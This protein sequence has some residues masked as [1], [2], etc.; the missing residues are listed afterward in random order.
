MASKKRVTFKHKETGAE[1]EG[2]ESQAKTLAKSGWEV[3]EAE[4]E[5]GQPETDEPQTGGEPA[6]IDQPPADVAPA[7]E[8]PATS[9]GTTRKA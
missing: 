7:P 8:Q 6:A 5:A 1:Y 3:V 9:R 4:P 2:F